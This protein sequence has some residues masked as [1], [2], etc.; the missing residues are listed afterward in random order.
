MYN[1]YMDNLKKFEE[2]IGG[3]FASHMKTMLRSEEREEDIRDTDYRH[4]Y[5]EE[6][7]P[8]CPNCGS[9]TKNIGHSGSYDRDPD[10]GEYTPK[11]NYQC[12]NNQCKHTFAK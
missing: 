5:N 2:Y 8:R 10:S 9:G 1:K 12:T 11:L 7:N 3:S 6:K 4:D